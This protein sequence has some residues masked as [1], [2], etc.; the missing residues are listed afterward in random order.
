MGIKIKSSNALAVMTLLGVSDQL[1]DW[2]KIAPVN[3]VMTSHHVRFTVQHHDDGAQDTVPLTLDDLHQLHA[4]K[5]SIPRKTE[6]RSGCTKAILN[7]Q[8]FVKAHDMKLAEPPPPAPE[9]KASA[10]MLNKLPPLKTDNTT[11]AAKDDPSAIQIWPV[12]DLKKI[13]SANPVKLRDATHMYQPVHGTS[14]GSRYFMVAAGKGIRVAVRYQV[15]QL[16]VR[17]EGDD[18]EKHLPKVLA[19]QFKSGNGYAS[20]H[21]EV[22]DPVMGAKTLGAILLG[23]G[24]PLETPLPQL[25]KTI[26]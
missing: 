12:F 13:H 11:A 10:P 8:A 4:G 9:P 5:L 1:V 22:G 24:I 21:L 17:I 23:L 26:A 3:V 6:L 2:L 20:L 18:L 16:S 15:G 19:N 25:E 7:M 14:S